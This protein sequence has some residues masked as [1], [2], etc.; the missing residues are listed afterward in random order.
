MLRAYFLSFAFYFS[1]FFVVLVSK[2]IRLQN[3]GTL[4][5]ILGIGIK[6]AYISKSRSIYLQVVNCS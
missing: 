2:A 1:F 6:Y 5:K 3:Y 4:E